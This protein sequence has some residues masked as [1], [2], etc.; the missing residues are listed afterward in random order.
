MDDDG[1]SQ[2]PWRSSTGNTEMLVEDL[3]SL[4]VK[5]EMLE[6]KFGTLL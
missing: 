4:A 1:Q 3:Q 2:Q 5:F 6:D